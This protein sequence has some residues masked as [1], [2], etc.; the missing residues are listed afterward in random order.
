MGDREACAN[1]PSHEQEPWMDDN[2]HGIIGSVA[3]KP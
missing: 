1:E 2:A 3:R